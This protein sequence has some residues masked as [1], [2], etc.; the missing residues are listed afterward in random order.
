MRACVRPRHLALCALCAPCPLLPPG[1]GLFTAGEEREGPKLP[2]AAMK[3]FRRCLLNRLRCCI[4]GANT[5]LWLRWQLLIQQEIA[6]K[7]PVRCRL[8]EFT[9]RSYSS[10]GSESRGCV[11]GD[12][13][14]VA[15]CPQEL[16]LLRPLPPFV[17]PPLAGKAAEMGI[18]SERV[19]RCTLERQQSV[20]VFFFF[21]IFLLTSPFY[22]RKTADVNSL[23]G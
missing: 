16:G 4:I 12:G 8:G 18:S 19:Y 20:F 14:A 7:H 5:V 13:A 21:F 9:P 6:S 2:G 15:A 17:E 1:W 11:P 22:S 23:R 3:R 10:P